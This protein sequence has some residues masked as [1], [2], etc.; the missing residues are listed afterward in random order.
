MPRVLIAD[1]SKPSLVMSSEIFKDKIA[2]TEVIVANSGAEALALAEKEQPDLCLIDFDLPDADGASLIVAMRKVYD[3]PILL[4]AFADDVAKQAASEL[5]FGYDDASQLLAKPVQFDDLSAR[6]D[7]FIV[8]KR[9]VGTRFDTDLETMVIAKAA[10][11]GK[12]APK[13]TGK[14][15]N[16]SLGGACVAMDTAIKM[17]KN[18][19]LTLAVSFPVAPGKPKATKT[20]TTKQKKTGT[21]KTAKKTTTKVKTVES[22]LKGTVC[23][24]TDDEVGLRFGK[25][26]EVQ[27]SGL[28]SFLRSQ[29]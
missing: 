6:V 1:S 27:R 21:K 14:V 16:L 17:K 7:T 18:Q 26:T 22:K 13:G 3:G 9:R 28:E 10:G 2:G 19:E 8:E 11:R 20:T 23:W 12:R 4:Q 25:L 15:T 24:I 29:C 5:L